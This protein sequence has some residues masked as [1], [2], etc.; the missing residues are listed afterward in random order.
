MKLSDS[1]VFPPFVEFVSFMKFYTIKELVKNQFRKCLTI[2]FDQTKG[3]P[4]LNLNTQDSLMML[5]LSN[6]YVF[7][8]NQ[9]NNKYYQHLISFIERKHAFSQ[10][11]IQLKYLFILIGGFGN[12][13]SYPRKELINVLF[14]L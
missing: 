6:D 11:F 9:P 12:I 4:K 8:N 7:W 5:T 2:H 14:Y 13:C 10:R 3:F 1:L